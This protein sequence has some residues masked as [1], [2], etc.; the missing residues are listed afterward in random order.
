M[1]VELK[2]L[3]GCGRELR[4]EVEK[5]KVEKEFK[6][7]YS[8]LERKAE[9]PGFRPG[10]VPTSVIKTRFSEE[11]KREVF[12]KLAP[13]SCFAAMKEKD[14]S[15]VIAP[16]I[17]EINLKE[18]TLSYKAYLEVAPQVNLG[19]YTGL[20]IKKE[21]RAIKKEEINKAL[22]EWAR[23]DPKISQAAL[24]LEERK[25]LKERIKKQLELQESLGERKE[26]EREILKLLRENSNLEAP[27]VFVAQHLQSLVREN[28]SK[29]DLKGKT[30]KEVEKIARDLEEKLRNGVREEVEFFFILKEI[31]KKEKIEVSE[32]EL[33]EAISDI[34][35]LNKG[36]P[37][38]LRKRL[39]ETG[40]LE[41]LRNQL[42]QNKV[43][44]FV[45]GR[46]KILWKPEKKIVLA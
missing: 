45:R 38:E 14:I 30:E 20:V 33:K 35:K 7:L 27:S 12:D 26:E 28:L 9:I 39:E 17:S 29:L 36:E 44:D 2:E 22:E 8:N 40:R 19:N 34:A 23:R 6:S 43:L 4:I 11:I 37:E 41:E 18:D 31:A 1:K 5:E 13:S 10:K 42:R 32:E 46:A 24:N 15:S 3:K 21:K 25:A 16:I